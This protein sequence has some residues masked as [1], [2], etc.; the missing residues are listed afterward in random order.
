[1]KIDNKYIN[2]ERKIIN[3]QIEKYMQTSMNFI[4]PLMTGLFSFSVPTGM[5][6]YW[7]IS[8]ISDTSNSIY[9]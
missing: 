9:E 7:I 3:D 4:A 2:K 6:L 1:M 5:G 8:N